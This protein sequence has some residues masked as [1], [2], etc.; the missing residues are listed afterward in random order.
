[1]PIAMFGPCVH[2]GGRGSKPGKRG[3]LASLNAEGLPYQSVEALGETAVV[4]FAS[5]CNNMQKRNSRW[6]HDHGRLQAP[7]PKQ[8]GPTGAVRRQATLPRPGKASLALAEYR[9]E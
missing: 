8:C 4:C 5:T 2:K 3:R 1:M 7:M 9:R 6:C